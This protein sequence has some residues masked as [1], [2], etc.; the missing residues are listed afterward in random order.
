M[1]CALG[2][3]DNA[4]GLGELRS[5]RLAAGQ[6]TADVFAEKDRSLAKA[7]GGNYRVWSVVDRE[8]VLVAAEFLPEKDSGG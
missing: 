6:E 3:V 2:R 4:E 8:P 7:L 5:N 1:G